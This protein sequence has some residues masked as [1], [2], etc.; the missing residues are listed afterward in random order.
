MRVLVTGG[1]GLLGGAVLRSAPTSVEVVATWRRATVAV[2]VPAR[3]VDL[4]DGDGVRAMLDDVRADV[5]IHT[6]YGKDDGRRDIEQ[7]TEILAEAT[8]DRGVGLVHV[9]SDTVFDGRSA[10]YAETA[11]TSPVFPYGLQKRNAETT[12]ALDPTAAIVR[13]SL[14]VGVDPVDAAS[15]WM[16][17]RLA[18]GEAATLFTDELRQPSHVDDVA[19]CLWEIAALPASER[20]GPWHV[21]G[22][23]VLTRYSLG[24]LVARRHGVAAAG[25]VPSLAAELPG[26][27]PPDLRLTTARLGD[28]GIAAPRPISAALAC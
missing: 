5:V 22:P 25:I 6:A 12:V 8:R 2:D 18:A 24:L 7:A 10:P 17:D 9:S 19:R 14:L 27:R 11:T 13:T 26:E 23:E 21:V 3:Q 16:L 28:A 4:A 20:G 15:R 1:A